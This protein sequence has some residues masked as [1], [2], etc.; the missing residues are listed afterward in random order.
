[1]I[2]SLVKMFLLGFG[3][4]ASFAGGYYW[5]R[6]QSHALGLSQWDVAGPGIVQA[7]AEPFLQTPAEAPLTD[8]DADS[9]KAE[10]TIFESVASEVPAPPQVETTAD[11]KSAENPLTDAI[12]NHL[13]ALRKLRSLE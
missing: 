1:M 9:S 5:A 13:E 3:F 2:H 12:R 11:A 7:D 8:D 4:A 10:S 6:N